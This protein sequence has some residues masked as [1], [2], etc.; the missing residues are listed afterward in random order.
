[1]KNG[2]LILL[3]TL[4]SSVTYSQVLDDFN[5]GDFT[6]NPI[7]EGD[8][9][10][11]KVNHNKQ[12]QLNREGLEGLSYLTTSHRIVDSVSWEFYIK[13]SFSPSANNYARVYLSASEADL[14]A[15]LQGWYL[16]FGE[17]GSD[18]ALELFRQDGT[19]HSSVCR[20][21]EGAISS[22]FNARI[23]VTHRSGDWEIYADFNNSG[24]YTLQCQ[25][26]DDTYHSTAF[27]GVFCQYTSSNATKFYFD[28]IDISYIELDEIPPEVL[29]VSPQGTHQLKVD[30]SEMLTSETALHT[31]NYTVDAEI[32]HPGNAVFGDSQK[33]VLLD[34]ATDFEPEKDYEIQISGVNDWSQNTMKDTAITFFRTEILEFD[35]V[36]NEIM[37]DPTPVVDLP[38]A[39]YLEIYNRTAHPIDLSAWVLEIGHSP[40]LFPS[41]F[42]SADSYLILCKSDDVETLSSYG[43]CVGFPSFSLTN[44]GQSLKLIAPNG[45]CIH[46]IHYSRDWYA[47]DE[48]DDGGWSMERIDPEDFCSAKDNWRAA[49]D[50]R[51]GSPGEINSV[52]G[53]TGDMAPPKIERVE[54]LDSLRIRL[55]FNKK[56]DSISYSNPLN[57]MF[58]MGLE[59]PVE[60]IKEGPEYQS[61]VLRLGQKLQKGIV[62][63][64]E[65]TTALR[66]CDGSDAGSLWASF[67]IPDNIE[68]GD[69]VFNEILF[70]AAVEDGE[71]LEL[72]NV[73]EKVL[74]AASL[75]IS[76]LK[77]NQYDTSWYS[78]QLP[79]RLLFPGDYIVYT[80][81][82][83]QVEKV[84][85][86]ENPEQIISLE[87]FISLPNDEGQLILHLKG[88]KDS[89]VDRLHY[90]EAWHYDLLH[91][92]KGVSLEK[93]DLHQGNIPENW[94]SAAS[95]V[96]YGTPAYENSQFLA[97]EK[98][99]SRFELVPEIF[100]PDNDGY[101]DVL[102]INYEMEAPGYTLNL[103]IYDS[104]GRKILHL[105][106]N[107]LLGISGSFY[108][109]GQTEDHQK[110]AIGIY[111]L[112]FEYFD[113][114]G[115]ATSEKLTTVLGGR[116]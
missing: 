93:I 112:Y 31:D 62:Y 10:D 78:V 7:W 68:R 41:V 92:T 89:V 60:C 27:F 21:V 47:D 56:M 5:D 80:S 96:N 86:S 54:V 36:F 23:K 14:S 50:I 75:S 24:T 107:E 19:T 76:R 63:T 67:A 99:S 103:V 12:L 52:D 61:V 37:A 100:S 17:S 84:Y 91:D 106:K 95:A 29:S 42:I 46:H 2:L 44:T 1:M 22:S 104:R 109:D 25:G 38:E 57:Y 116:L 65:T 55:Y 28:D 8:T 83:E 87:H 113:L 45:I 74:E 35:V 13:L 101:D 4:L 79:G 32:G 110:A 102:Q 33:E 53:L 18:D 90:E 114:Q 66:L 34:F 97:S 26:F 94:H 30:F 105:L 20:G 64:L 72:V 49:I 15:S 11:F 82:R 108:W 6:Q 115:H 3:L 16:Q 73:S 70:D 88:S 43:S 9:E 48:K 39:E 71:Y 59:H 69:I 81:S 40:K 98:P 58:D 77:P 111:I 51:G 85:Y